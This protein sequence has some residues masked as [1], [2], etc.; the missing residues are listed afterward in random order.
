MKAGVGFFGFLLFC[1]VLVPLGQPPAW[2]QDDVEQFVRARCSVCHSFEW[3]SSRKKTREGWA[4]TLE[5]V[6]SY[7]VEDIWS[8]RITPEFREKLLDYLTANFGPPKT[9]TAAYDLLVDSQTAKARDPLVQKYCTQCHGLELVAANRKTPEG[10]NFT[11]QQ[12]RWYV[13]RLN[14]ERGNRPHLPGQ[15]TH[16]VANIPPE[17][18]TYL[19]RYLARMYPILPQEL[20]ANQTK[21]FD[22]DGER[23]CM[24]CHGMGTIR[25]QVKSPEAWEKTVGRMEG[26]QTQE[27]P[28]FR[29]GG[30]PSGWSGVWSFG[31]RYGDIPPGQSWSQIRDKVIQSLKDT[32][33]YDSDEW[34]RWLAEGSR[35][36]N[37]L[38]GTWEVAGRDD[39]GSYEGTIQFRHRAQTHN[40]YDVTRTITY[41][42]SGQTVTWSGEADLYGGSSLRTWYTLTS[43]PGIL[44]AVSAAA[45]GEQPP[46]G[47]KIPIRGEFALSED[48]MVFN[49]HWKAEGTPLPAGE[50]KYVRRAEAMLVLACEP[51]SVRRGETATVTILGRGLPPQEAASTTKVTF[52]DPALSVLALE[53]SVDGGR[54]MRA[55]FEVAQDAEIGW[56]DISVTE[57]RSG[58]EGTG[59]KLLVVYDNIHHLRVEPPLSVARLGEAPIAPRVTDTADSPRGLARVVP[60]V[61]T[62]FKAAAYSNG[63]D[64]SPGTADDVRI[65]E[66]PVE[67]SFQAVDFTGTRWRLSNPPGNDPYS[68]EV[69]IEPGAPP[70]GDADR[71]RHL[72]QAKTVDI[73]GLGKFHYVPNREKQAFGA[74]S[75]SRFTPSV[76]SPQ[77]DLEESRAPIPR[78][79]RTNTGDFRGTALL[80]ATYRDPRGGEP[81]VGYGVVVVSP[82]DWTPW[83][84]WEDDSARYYY[85]AL[86]PSGSQGETSFAGEQPP[87]DPAR[88]DSP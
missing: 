86:R 56:K 14:Q 61:P 41:S 69:K 58:R 73:P 64:G 78:T 59:R 26:S 7:G 4:E 1:C 72:A 65:R 30:F 62:E 23:V 11:V 44:G 18:A 66:V 40:Q 38:E 16:V 6:R 57:T 15:Q 2:G 8:A 43:G 20:A 31:T 42:G 39:T 10:W 80:S 13:H 60:K 36:E 84:P 51:D 35:Q 46:E 27:V 45:S 77:I 17:D 71:D 52:S 50:E 75:G 74:L 83:I 25:Q 28:G 33:R 53:G 29:R 48:R 54:S 21:P 47:K 19:A 81:I 55:R 9:A 32:F 85:S 63:P 70:S 67:W 87:G 3:A 76:E 82:P 37:L 68:S 24:S 12:M 22:A 34:R 5:R 79:A 49:G 88:P